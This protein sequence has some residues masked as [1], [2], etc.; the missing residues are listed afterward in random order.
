MKVFSIP[1]HTRFRGITV[2]EGISTEKLKELTRIVKE[3]NIKV[4]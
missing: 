4:E 2:R 1:M 3:A